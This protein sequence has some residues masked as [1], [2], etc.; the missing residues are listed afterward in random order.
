MLCQE[1]EVLSI[2]FLITDYVPT[3]HIYVH[4][5]SDCK[6]IPW[7]PRPGL[8]AGVVHLSIFLT[9]HTAI[10]GYLYARA[11][12]KFDTFNSLILY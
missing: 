11:Y 1:A 9:S 8:G 7:Y 2:E 3:I 4:D 6:F 12:W 10:L 5:I